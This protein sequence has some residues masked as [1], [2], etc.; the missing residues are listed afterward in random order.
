MNLI[1]RDVKT[2]HNFVRYI[3]SIECRSSTT[4]AVTIKWN[5]AVSYMSDDKAIKGVTQ[6]NFVFGIDRIEWT[7]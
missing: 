5:E 3:N 4:R 2:N 1:Q 7:E 6:P